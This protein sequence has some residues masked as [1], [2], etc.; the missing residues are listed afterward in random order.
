MPRFLRLTFLLFLTWCPGTPT[1]AANG[2]TAVPLPG[3]GYTYLT[4]PSGKMFR[5][6]KAGPVIG[7]QGKKLCTMYSYAGESIEVARITGDAIEL[8]RAIGPE[9]ELS[10]ETVVIV[11][12]NVGNDPNKFISKSVSYN[13]AFELKDGGWSRSAREGAEPLK[14]DAVDASYRPPEDPSFPYDL[15]KGTE[16]RKF[17][18]AWLGTLDAGAGDKALESTSTAFRGQV[19]PSQW[20][21]ILSKRKA[22]GLPGKRMDLYWLQPRI[23]PGTDFKEVAVGLMFEARSTQGGRYLERVMLTKEQNSWRIAGYSF[24]RISPGK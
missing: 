15:A 11:Q 14:L 4:T 19:S 7:N 21:E 6:L 13:V 22:L 3:G 23:P 18:G 24:Q 5:V 10:G 17:A 8:M 9:M 12:T 16:A 2:E 20:H 1:S